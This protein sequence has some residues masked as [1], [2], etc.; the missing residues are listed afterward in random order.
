MFGVKGRARRRRS[1]QS[2]KYVYQADSMHARNA[3]LCASCMQSS[4]LTSCGKCSGPSDFLV[5]F[6]VFGQLFRH[7]RPS[8]SLVSGWPMPMAMMVV[9]GDYKE[10]GKLSTQDSRRGFLSSTLSSEILSSFKV[11]WRPYFLHRFFLSSPLF[12]LSHTP[13]P[14]VVPKY[15]SMPPHSL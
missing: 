12:P 3:A 14:P 9:Q 13:S 5:V 6:R 15:Q 7:L 11:L 1:S 10:R 8:F 2:L 4:I